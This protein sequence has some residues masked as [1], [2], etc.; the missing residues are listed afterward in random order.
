MAVKEMHAIML[1][2]SEEELARLAHDLLPREEK[3]V[4]HI[5]RCA[6][7]GVAPDEEWRKE[8]WISIRSFRIKDKITFVSSSELAREIGEV[9]ISLL[10]GKRGSEHVPFFFRADEVARLMASPRAFRAAKAAERLLLPSQSEWEDGEL[11]SRVYEKTLELH[12]RLFLQEL[13]KRMD[14]KY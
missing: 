9:A 4:W 13:S 5:V 2:F 7:H 11:P 6:L 12:K 3:Y 8:E 10:E 1:T 14:A